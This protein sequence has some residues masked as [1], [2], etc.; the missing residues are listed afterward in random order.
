VLIEAS[1]LAR[2]LGIKL[3]TLE[4]TV[5]A[6][7]AQVRDIIEAPPSAGVTSVGYDDDDVATPERRVGS[8]AAGEDSPQGQAVGVR[9]G[10]VAELLRESSNAL[11]DIDRRP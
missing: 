5:V 3:L 10:L 1:V 8:L 7:P 9:L 11:H 2:L 6:S 4:G